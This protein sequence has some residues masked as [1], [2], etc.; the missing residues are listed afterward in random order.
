MKITKNSL[1]ALEPRA[2]DY[3]VWDD[4]LPGFGVRIW[5]TGKQTYV[6]MYR[7]AGG[8]QRKMTVG[9][10]AVMTPDEARDRARKA[11]VDVRDGQDPHRD[12]IDRRTAETVADLHRAF[13]EVYSQPRVKKNTEEVYGRLW[14]QYLLPRFGREKLAEVTRE[15]LTKFHG[16]LVDHPRTANMA[17]GV[18]RVALNI[19]VERGWIAKNPALKMKQYPERRRQMVLTPEQMRALLAAMDRQPPR[20]WA[21]V[22]LYRLLLFTGLRLREW[23]KA[24]WSWINLDAGMMSLPDT[25]TGARVVHF[26]DEVRVILLQIK[27]HPLS[28]KVWVFPNE[29][30]TGPLTHPYN[31]WDDIVADTGLKGLR[32]HDLRHTFASYSLLS[33]ANIKEVQQM[34]GHKTLRTT[35]RYVGVFDETIRSAQSRTASTLMDAAMS[36]KL[37]GRVTAPAPRRGIRTAG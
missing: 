4:A 9:Q 33:G 34:L 11:L 35:E 15:A 22:F 24:E 13:M 36:G 19:A 23:A 17:L 18:M 12:K 8:T 31:C 28:S 27:S 30:H 7:T 21:S 29:G 32:M 37:P 6:L 16:E 3:V 14:R 20:R 2:K 25:K 5:P 10:A 1:K 26:G